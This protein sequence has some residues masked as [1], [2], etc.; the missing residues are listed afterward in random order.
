MA[1]DLVPLLRGTSSEP[2]ALLP[3]AA[4]NSANDASHLVLASGSAWF[5]AHLLA[6]GCPAGSWVGLQIKH[7]AID[8][9]QNSA[10]LTI[11]DDAIHLPAGARL[12]VDLWPKAVLPLQPQAG[13]GEDAT[14]LICQFPEQV[15]IECLPDGLAVAYLE[16]AAL[17]VYGAAVALAWDN[18]PAVY[19]PLIKHLVIPC[20]AT[21]Q[22]F[23][24]AEQ[25][26]TLFGLGGTAAVTLAGWALPVTQTTPDLLGQADGCGALG[27]A[28]GPGLKAQW[29]S[30]D[31]SQSLAQA[32]LALRPGEL[33]L[34]ASVQGQQPPLTFE[35]WGEAA[36]QGTND[37]S[38]RSSLAFHPHRSH[39]L[40]YCARRGQELI[41]WTAR[42][43][44]ISTAPCWPMGGA[45]AS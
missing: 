10:T 6:D 20:Q 7:G 36:G 37:V 16:N 45:A 40:F 24:A 29:P 32:V 11:D 22:Q 34:V 15:S 21:P 30:L 14:R 9:L 17:T 23:S 27:L 42:R 13:P 43:S 8:V 12:R 4:M 3:V 38:R 35:L 2:F 26:S 44:A 28:L 33:S 41:R 39:S 18:A 31:L 1:V 19:A 25:H 5:N